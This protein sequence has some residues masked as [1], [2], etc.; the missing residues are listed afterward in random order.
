MALHSEYSML[1]GSPSSNPDGSDELQIQDLRLHGA[2]QELSKLGNVDLVADM[3]IVSLVGKQL[4]NMTG[5]SGK[6][7]SVLGENNINIEMISQG[8]SSPPRCSPAMPFFR[9]SNSGKRLIRLLGA[10]EINI[11]CVIWERDADRALNVVHTSLFTF[12]E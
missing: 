2:V 8:L 3:A 9:R 7:F 4:K 5:I 10:S 12:L 11:S 1:S 6:F